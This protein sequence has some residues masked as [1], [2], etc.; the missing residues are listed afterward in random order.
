MLSV[1]E[2]TMLSQSPLKVLVESYCFPFLCISRMKIPTYSKLDLNL[3]LKLAH[4]KLEPF[5]WK[6]TVLCYVSCGMKHRQTEIST[7][8]RL[9]KKPP[10]VNRH[11]SSVSRKFSSSCLVLPCWIL[12]LIDKGQGSLDIKYNFQTFRER[13]RG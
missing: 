8:N 10:N 6:V 11:R 13:D 7:H 9:P 3:G 5:E 2:N 4:L 1:A 12:F